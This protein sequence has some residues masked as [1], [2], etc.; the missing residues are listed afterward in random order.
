MVKELMAFSSMRCVLACFLLCPPSME[1][2]VRPNRLID[3][4]VRL[5]PRCVQNLFA[6]CAFSMFRSFFSLPRTTLLFIGVQLLRHWMCQ[7]FL[8]VQLDF[9]KWVVHVRFLLGDSL[10]QPPL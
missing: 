2:L 5:R 9:L 8:Q 4:S 3:F 6:F 7:L 10:V 1:A